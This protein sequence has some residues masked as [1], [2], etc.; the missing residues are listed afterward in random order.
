MA[1]GL[2]DHLKKPDMAREAE[3]VLAD[4]GWLPMVL[5]TPGLAGTGYAASDDDT[6]DGE[7]LAVAAE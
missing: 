2:I 1:A 3:R 7:P 6:I 4:S 5:R